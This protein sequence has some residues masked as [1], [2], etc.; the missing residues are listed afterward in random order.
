M[1]VMFFGRD[2]RVVRNRDYPPARIA[3]GISERVKLFQENAGNAC[4]LFKFP[5]SSLH[6]RFPAT[7][8]SAGNSP[9]ASKRLDITLDQHDLQGLFLEIQPEDHAINRQ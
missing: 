3:I 6:Q 8:E 2:E 5:G 7:H 4:L 9:N 1:N